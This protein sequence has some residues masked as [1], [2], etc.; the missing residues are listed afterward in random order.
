MV[1]AKQKHLKRQHAVNASLSAWI[2]LFLCACVGN[3]SQSDSGTGDKHVLPGGI[4]LVSEDFESGPNSM[5]GQVLEEPDGNRFLRIVP[6]YGSF[7]PLNAYGLYSGITD[8]SISF[9]Y[10]RNEL[11]AG[12]ERLSMELSLRR[13]ENWDSRLELSIRGSS[14]MLALRTA[15][16]DT[17]LETKALPI[18]LKPYSWT[19]YD[20]SCVGQLLVLSVGSYSLEWK[21]PVVSTGFISFTGLESF[22][23]DELTI[24]VLDADRGGAQRAADGSWYLNAQMPFASS[25][26]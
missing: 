18:V 22:D 6:G 19:R 1:F 15:K 20:I 11:S 10:R 12:D 16:G 4:V 3:A 21:L 8:C 13:S 26:N 14:A 7:S 24:S 17:N 2:A 25:G 9:L 5:N 23:I